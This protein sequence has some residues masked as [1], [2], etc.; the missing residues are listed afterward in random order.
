MKTLRADFI[1]AQRCMDSIYSMYMAAV[2]SFGGDPNSSEA[3]E[4]GAKYARK[5][6]LE[7][8]EEFE[9]VYGPWAWYEPEEEENDETM[10]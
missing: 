8:A 5:K 6:F 7:I 2:E 4:E 9:A 1:V 10:G 3:R